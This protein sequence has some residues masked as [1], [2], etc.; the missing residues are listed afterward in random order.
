MPRTIIT[1]VPSLEPPKLETWTL[2]LKTITPMFG[3]SAKV[4]EVDP[5]NP[6]RAASIRGHLRFWW[7]ATAGARFSSSE[8][9]FKAEE[10]IWGSAEKPGLVSVRVELISEGIKKPCAVFREGKTLA[11][12]GSYPSYALFPFQGKAE[13]D[14]STGK[15]KIIELPSEAL[16]DV[17]FK[18]Y[19]NYPSKIETQIQS[20]GMAWIQYGGIGARTRRGCGSLEVINQGSV[21]IESPKRESNTL[22]TLFPTDYFIG[23]SVEDTPIRA[24]KQAVDLYRDFRQGVPFARKED[25]NPKNVRTNC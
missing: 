10:E 23:K 4:R 2:E 1:P 5:E 3:G 14:K 15:V 16:R 17:R 22:L 18:L 24:W 8:E 7:R 11:D 21:A 6:I 20:A 25:S 13:K 9:L 19:L 12:F